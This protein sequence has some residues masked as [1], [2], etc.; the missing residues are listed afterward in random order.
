MKAK[1]KKKQIYYDLEKKKFAIKN[2]QL[3]QFK[4][5]SSEN[6]YK[7]IHYIYSIYILKNIYKVKFIFL[8]WLILPLLNRSY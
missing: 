3:C 7:H 8:I 2:K 1:T 5:K 6:N 4:F